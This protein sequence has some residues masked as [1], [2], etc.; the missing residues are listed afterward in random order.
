MM[1]KEKSPDRN[2]FKYLAA[3]PLIM[4]ILIVLSCTK[5]PPP[6]PPP[7][8][9]PVTETEVTQV[10]DTSKAF[11]IV[12]ENAKFQNGSLEEFGQW[13][14]KNMVYPESAIKNSIS[15]KVMVQFAVDKFG[16]VADVTVVRSASPTLSEE[17]IRVIQSSPEW[18]PAKL[19]G[20]SVKQQFVMPVVFALK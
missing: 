14:Q 7:P 8:P 16:K 2:R 18:T 19:G 11:T 17:A 4:A 13:V 9:P 12:D 1:T 6:P 5:N 15:G 3:L 20:N 10:S